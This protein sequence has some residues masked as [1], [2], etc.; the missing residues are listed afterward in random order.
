MGG[1][2]PSLGDDFPPRYQAREM[3]GQGAFGAVFRAFDQS[4]GREVALKILLPRPGDTRTPKRF[5]REARAASRVQHPNLVPI[6]E[7]GTTPKGRPYATFELLAGETLAERLDREGRLSLEA[8]GKL[9]R[10]ILLG[11]EAL[12]QAGVLHRDLKEENLIFD[13]QGE[14]RIAD[15]G[16]AAEDVDQTALT[17]TGEILGT[18]LH[19]APE[20]IRGLDLGP[21]A[22][23]FGFGTV[24]YRC[25]Y[26]ESWRKIQSLGE[27]FSEATSRELPLAEDERLG[28][29]PGWD[30]FL[31]RLLRKDPE[32]RVESAAEALLGLARVEAGELDP[33]PPL[34]PELPE[35]SPPR[36]RSGRLVGF[37]I[38][39]GGM[40]L[41]LLAGFEPSSTPLPS[42][43]DPRVEV[44]SNTT[45]AAAEA[46]VR[47]SLERLPQLPKV[48]TSKAAFSARDTYLDASLPLR[49]SRLFE[50]LGKLRIELQRRP[51]RRVPGAPLGPFF[52]EIEDR[53]RRFCN[54][55][56]RFE[57]RSTK[58]PITFGTFDPKVTEV[59]QGFRNQELELLGRTRRFLEA[60]VQAQ[61]LGVAPGYDLI[62]LLF[63]E[64][65]EFVVGAS[66][67]P[68]LVEAFAQARGEEK[69]RLGSRLEDLGTSPEE[70]G[71]SDRELADLFRVALET[72][73]PESW[74][75]EPKSQNL[76]RAYL[77]S[78]AI[79]ILLRQEENPAS[80]ELARVFRRGW[81]VLAE[82]DFLGEKTRE[83]VASWDRRFRHQVGVRHN[84]VEKKESLAL[85][86]WR[87]LQEE[88][89]QALEALPPEGRPSNRGSDSL[90][91]PE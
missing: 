31:F 87:G 89:A 7:V 91:V 50:S 22:D 10:G 90:H 6:Y 16:L 35:P 57:D 86:P 48:S 84:L 5:L 8:C 83:W 49:L 40:T 64:M 44:D 72:D 20:M 1:P 32:A 13:A 17:R 75:V 19:M 52:L 4:L 30:P 29:F 76:A 80:L 45:L 15:L 37:G 66:A 85:S 54:R 71:V 81:K 11:L 74:K 47:S 34:A 2:L 53:L 27:L 79:P 23:L 21:P 46:T 58:F 69:L 14:I 63:A 59:V 88:L 60:E 9:A 18:P 78:G 12:H 42:R 65:S 77:L 38:L 68:G 62:L 26:G 82:G 43:I 55:L 3:L 73:P 41:G 70:L 39:L 56:D 36:R 28:K 51:P 25:L 67:L 61:A 33:W 24:L